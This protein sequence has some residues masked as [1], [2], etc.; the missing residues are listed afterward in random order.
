MIIDAREFDQN[1][2]ISA[3]VCVVGAGAAGITLALEL[4]GKFQVALLE[5]GGLTSDPLTQQLY[6][7]SNVGLAHDPPEESRSRFLGG[8]TNCWGGWCRPLDRL[9]FHVRSWVPNSGWPIEKSELEPFYARSQAWLGLPEAPYEAE[10]WSEVIEARGARLLPLDGS[11]LDNLLDQLSPPIRFGTAYRGRLKTA[12]DLQVLLYANATHILATRTAREVTGVA[13]RT[14][15]EKAFNVAARVVV[16]AAGGIENPRLLLA[17]NSIQ[18]AGLGNGHDLVGRYYMDHPRACSARL[19]LADANEYRPLYDATLHRLHRGQR[20][21]DI[22]VH[23]APSVATQQELGLPNS[24]T[25]FV[26]RHAND[27]SQSFFALKAIQR[28]IMGRK[29]FGYPL[30]RAVNDV[31]RQ[32]PRLL[33]NARTTAQTIAEL[34]LASLWGRKELS[35]E[36]VIEPVPNPESRVRLSRDRDAL[37]VPR[38]EINW[39]LTGQDRSHFSTLTN[40]VTKELVRLG[41]ARKVDRSLEQEV[42][43]PDNVTGCWHHMGTTRMHVD[44]TRGVVDADCKVHGISN[45]YIAGSS[46]FPTVGSD[47]PT[48]TLVALAI[49]L[50]ERIK[51]D[52][53]LAD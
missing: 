49:R 39:Q 19:E 10:A 50:A 18:T 1:S 4:A 7:G 47:S 11:A 27:L 30:R 20:T 38:V 37:G 26:A 28:A 41:V 5:G 9:D 6:C 43:W 8:S 46:V 44:P 42:Q 22:E 53:R 35:L 12:P 36:S 32:V 45:L 2:T 34:R 13:V 14:L 24:R 15:N 21:R 23:L 29:V 25:Y 52:F 16:L 17:S 33:G 51:A 3:D 31:F 48:I 40:L